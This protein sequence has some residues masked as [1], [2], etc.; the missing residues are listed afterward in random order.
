MA[1]KFSNTISSNVSFVDG[2]IPTAAKLNSVFNILKNSIKKLECAIGDLQDE[3]YPYFGTDDTLTQATRSSLNVDL[4]EG[5]KSLQI[6]NIAR[7]IGPSSALNPLHLSDIEVAESYVTESIPSGVNSFLVKYPIQSGTVSFSGSDTTAF[8]SQKVSSATMLTNGD[9]YIDN[10]TGEIFCIKATVSGTTITYQPANTWAGFASYSGASFNVIPDPSQSTKC[11][12]TGP[13]DGK[14]TIT[15]PVIERQEFDDT[16]LTTSISESHINY[17]AQLLLPSVLDG[18][19]ADDIIPQGFLYL[20]DDT[21][22]KIYKDAV[23]YYS[24]QSEIKVGN[25]TLDTANDFSIITVGTNITQ[26]IQHLNLKLWH[27]RRGLDGYSALDVSD[28]SNRV[29]SANSGKEVYVP[30]EAPNNYFPQYLHRDGWLTS[31]DNG[32]I[33]DQNGMRG[34]LVLL[35]TTRTSNSRNNLTDSSQ[36]LW[37]GKYTDGPYIYYHYVPGRSYLHLDAN[38]KEF[39]LNGD[40]NIVGGTR[41]G[42]TSATYPALKCVYDEGTKGADYTMTEN[43]SAS[44]AS[45]ISGKTIVGFT[46]LLQDAG[47]YWVAPGGGISDIDYSVRI[48][49]TEWLVNLID[50]SGAWPA[51]IPY[52]FCI[53]YV[54]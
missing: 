36:K 35:S 9:Y 40:T 32:N 15:L 54:D 43:W 18:M 17:G 16:G 45:A 5:D 13:V 4:G 28:L 23:Y 22:N 49:H 2:E 51:P 46:A 7:L 25:V 24:S 47:G 48:N 44:V 6:T 14:Y 26:S 12:A 30:S 21:D 29:G 52:R 3:S 39:Y 11:T 31:Y 1:D 20:K 37:F 50:P 53:Y 8:T 34:D 27:L 42:G 19:T 41:L 10:D 38:G 33:N